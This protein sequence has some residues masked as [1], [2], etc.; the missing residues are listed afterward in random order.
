MSQ[1]DLPPVSI[2]RYLDLLK[3]RR[4]Q[5]IPASLVGLLIGGIVAFFIPRFYVATA[6][7]TYEQPPG[8]PLTNAEDPFGA[9]IDSAKLTIPAAIEETIT[10][11]GWPEAITPDPYVR[12]ENVNAIAER[13]QIYEYGNSKGRTYAQIRVTYK[14]RD[15][16]RA[17]S[18]LN[19][20]VQT[21]IS[22]RQQRM[23][24]G[25][26]KKLASSTAE[27][28]QHD[29]AYNSFLQQRL[30]LQT[31]YGIEPLIDPS[32]R[33]EGYLARIK[34]A[35][36]QRG[37]VRQQKIEVVKLEQQLK[38]A[39]ET[40]SETPARVPLDMAMLMAEASKT[41]R[42]QVLLGLILQA[43]MA[44]D[45]H[46]DPRKKAKWE[47]KIAE[48]N[49]ELKLLANA[50][51]PDAD[52]MI[53]NV[54]HERLRLLVDDFDAKIKLANA[55]IPLDED[56]LEK[57]VERLRRKADGYAQYAAVEERLEESRAAKQAASER[58][59]SDRDTVAQLTTEP[60]IR[61]EGEAAVPPAP[62]DPNLLVVALLGCV[63]GLL[64]ATGIVLL[65]DLIRGSFNTVEEVERALA[66]PVLGSVAFLE[67]EA[68]RRDLARTRRRAT[69]VAATF[70]VLIG[71]VVLLYYFDPSRLPPIVR[72]VLSMVLGGT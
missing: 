34:A 16:L 29:E 42:G 68:Q 1:L 14:D 54:E 15:G 44:R 20:L 59:R 39:R 5:V 18:F 2:A 61:A 23:L 71:G 22:S 60:P 62:T 52:G 17:A 33:R 47:R 70:L 24:E 49:E 58:V 72:D 66:V 12:G 28:K 63:I 11:L 46:R 32:I 37:K 65:L 55:T 3:R 10:T 25:A 51:E 36:D 6:G 43:T 4:W 53:P 45:G 30:H 13:L 50:P 31:T 35:D 27:F 41:E 7:I 67:T 8:Q 26:R 19:Q 40:L 64:A 21:W 48:L 69:V 57:E 56:A 38:L 9:I